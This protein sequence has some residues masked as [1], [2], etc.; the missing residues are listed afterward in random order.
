M[1]TPPANL[2]SHCLRGRL[3]DAHDLT[4]AEALSAWVESEATLVCETDRAD[5]LLG[6]IADQ[7]RAID[8]VADE[9]ARRPLRWWPF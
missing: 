6:I 5:R 1:V 4:V 7:N 8:T 3:P 2:A 9:A